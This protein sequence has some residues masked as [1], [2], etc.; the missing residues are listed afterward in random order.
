MR[1]FYPA[2][3]SFKFE[4]DKKSFRDKKN[5]KKTSSALLIVF[6]RYVRGTYLSRKDDN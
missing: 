3:L 6:T 5:K 2:R 1:I 4:G